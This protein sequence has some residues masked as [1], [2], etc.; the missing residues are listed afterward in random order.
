MLLIV[1]LPQTIG[2]ARFS[3]A[4]PII[5]RYTHIINILKKENQMY[6]ITP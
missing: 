4:K 3:F 2:D 1:V 6:Q 5:V